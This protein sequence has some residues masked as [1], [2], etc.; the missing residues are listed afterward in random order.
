MTNSNFDCLGHMA[1]EEAN[2][3][4]WTILLFIWHCNYSLQDCVQDCLGMIWS[5]M[6]RSDLQEQRWREVNLM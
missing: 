2:S 6:F 4:T 5:G 3:L 1:R